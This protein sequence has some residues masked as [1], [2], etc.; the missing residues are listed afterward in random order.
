MQRVIEERMSGEAVSDAASP[1]PLKDEIVI[2][3]T[4]LKGAVEL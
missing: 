4:D 2:D 3:K 1:G